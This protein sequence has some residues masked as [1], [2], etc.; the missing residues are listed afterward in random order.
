M[1]YFPTS[2]AALAK[3]IRMEQSSTQ[4]RVH[5]FSWTDF[6]NQ[7]AGVVMIVWA[8]LINF[9]NPIQTTMKTLETDFI[10]SLSIAKVYN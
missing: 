6:D 7:V 2:S 4:A 8:S 1:K 3:L 10:C 9:G 5:F